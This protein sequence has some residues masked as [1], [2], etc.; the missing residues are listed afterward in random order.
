MDHSDYEAL[1]A[2]GVAEA[3]GELAGVFSLEIL[4]ECDSTNSRLLDNPPPGDG[5]VHVLAAERTLFTFAR[6]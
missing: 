2:G 4:P 6:S 3:L 5:R 1:D